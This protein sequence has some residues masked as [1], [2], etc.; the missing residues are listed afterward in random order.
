MKAIAK[1]IVASTD[2]YTPPQPQVPLNTFYVPERK[3][4]IIIGATLIFG[5]IFSYSS[6]EYLK[7]QFP[8]QVLELRNRIGKGFVTKFWNGLLAVHVAEAAYTFLTCLRRG[9]YSPLNTIKWTL[10]SALFGIG[11][12]KQLSKHAR[13]VAGLKS[14]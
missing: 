4:V 7:R 12:L 11:S 8:I 14:K 3:T 6:D 9:W 13:D 5:T 10:S 1:A 2:I